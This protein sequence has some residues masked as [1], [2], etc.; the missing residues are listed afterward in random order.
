MRS[1]GTSPIRYILRSRFPGLILTGTD[2]EGMAIIMCE[3]DLVKKYKALTRGDTILESSLHLNLA[4]HL[5][6]EIA[7]GT[8]SS[9]CTATYVATLPLHETH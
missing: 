1:I 6:S 7:L 5:N 9:L 8:I 4:E 2:T 3:T